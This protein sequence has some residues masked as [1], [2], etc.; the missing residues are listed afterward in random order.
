MNNLFLIAGFL[1]LLGCA[2]NTANM[3]NTTVAVPP[4][5]P[6]EALASV[7]CDAGEFRGFGTGA[8]E[9]EALN[10]ARF[11]IARQVHSSVKVS[12]KQI[13]NQRVSSGNENLSSEF[14]AETAVESAL[15]NAHDA[16]VRSVAHGANE[17]GVVAC[18]SRADAVKGF[19][20]RQRLVADSL[21]FAANASF[22][23]KHP[24]L[25]NE[26]WQRTQALW[27][28]FTRLQGMIDGL[29]AEK[30]DYLE[31]INA[32]YAQ[33]R[34]IYLSYCKA[35]KFHWEGTGGECSEVVFSVLSGKV[36]MEKAEC[37]NENGLR[38]KLACSE[39]CIPS[40]FGGIEC[41]FESSLSVE[42]CKGES[43][44]LLKTQK[45]VIG[46]DMHS[47]SK[48]RENL[49]EKLSSAEFTGEWEKELRG[50]MPLCAE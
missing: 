24:K 40:S 27:N 19:I 5:P 26:A 31:H 1:V 43:Y 29:G 10:A 36:K 33:A 47:T 23:A 44:L 25:K 16:R 22:E 28:E 13:L 17:V 38:L 11:S 8:S 21:E 37:Q 18:M 2:A 12:E 30:P 7:Q 3:A 9:E 48:A 46:K 6:A 15:S 42:S 45:P 35:Q 39:K 14:V 41:F 20:Q 4:A 34:E 49:M 32:T 50:W